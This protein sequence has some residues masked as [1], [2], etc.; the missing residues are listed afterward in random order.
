VSGTAV[1]DTEKLGAG[2]NT[3]DNLVDDFLPWFLTCFK[4]NC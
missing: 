3:I 2:V 1:P 4:E